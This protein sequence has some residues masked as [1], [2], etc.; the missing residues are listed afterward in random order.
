MTMMKAVSRTGMAAAADLQSAMQGEVLLPW[1]DNYAQARAIWNGAVD[2]QPMLIARCETKR[3]VQMAVRAAAARGLRLSVRGGGHDWAGR[4]VCHDGLTIDL[5]RMRQVKVEAATKVAIVGGGAS[6]GD[7]IE[8]AAPHGLAAVTGNCSTVGMAGP[9]LGGGYGLLSGRYGLALDNLSGAEVVLANGQFV[10]ADATHNAELFWALR[11]GGGNFGVVTSMRIRLYPLRSLLAGMILFPWSEAELVLRGY[12]KL[13][14]SAPDNLSAL[15]GAISGPDEKP[16]LFLAPA[17][18]GD[19][20]EGEPVVAALQNLGN[21][22]TAQIG[23]T[24]FSDL[25]GVLTQTRRLAAT[26]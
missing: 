4:S 20:K 17:W 9:T 13:M 1:D 11:G 21:P 19:L 18:C 2:Y 5:S 14:A 15:V 3:D 26:T 12:A 25:L 22:I 8:A 16:V 6:G 23:P 24:A 7:V 10:S